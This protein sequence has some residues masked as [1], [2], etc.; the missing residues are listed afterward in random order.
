MSKNDETAFDELE[1]VKDEIIITDPSLIMI[2][3]HEK[4]KQ[5]LK[6]L[7]ENALTIQE[8]KKATNLNPGTIKRHLDDLVKNKLVYVSDIQT[9]NYNIVMKFYRA[10]AKKF[11]INFIVQ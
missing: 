11:I 8:L 9:N 10:T 2:V 7:L 1:K 6:L 3:I 4:K 5:I